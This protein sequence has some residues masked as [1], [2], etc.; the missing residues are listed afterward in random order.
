MK[1]EIAVLMLLGVISLCDQARAHPWIEKAVGQ[2]F[3]ELSSDPDIP[4]RAWIRPVRISLSANQSQ[5]HHET[6][7]PDVS[8]QPDPAA[9]RSAPDRFIVII[10]S[11]GAAW[12]AA[13]FKPPKDPTPVHPIGLQ[14]AL[15]TS[16]D[17]KVLY[18]ARPCQFIS[19]DERLGSQDPKDTVNN[20]LILARHK[21]TSCLDER[22]WT[23]WRYRADVIDQYAKLIEDQLKDQLPS[24]RHSAH[25]VHN[26]QH[27]WIHDK[28]GQVILL[29]FS[30]GGSVA[31]LLAAFFA[32]K[33]ARSEAI[34]QR[35]PLAG[36]SLC[37]ITLAAP[38]DLNR[39]AKHHRL[40]LF[41]DVPSGKLLAE[42]ILALR[43]FHAFGGRDRK[44]PL[45]SAGDFLLTDSWQDR[46][47]Q[48]AELAHDASW[49]RLWPDLLHRACVDA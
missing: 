27:T 21:Q 35:G 6:T 13:G 20:D 40:S 29:G 41:K 7:S 32:A 42:K 45:E 2:G 39:W 22:W 28:P 25:H 9:I 8:D 17:A 38:L 37:L 10:E 33:A 18:L 3:R 26:N 15:R 11:D 30:G 19:G 24:P 48:Y 14:M 47:H 34:D 31:A 1:A 5:K 23:V 36:G 16:P 44:V 4:F 46:V 12:R 43:S 49:I